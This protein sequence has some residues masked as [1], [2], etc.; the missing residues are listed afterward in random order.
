MCTLSDVRVS[1]KSKNL[2]QV[3]S[4][5]FNLPLTPTSESAHVIPAVLFDPENVDVA[6]AISLPSCVQA[7]LHADL[8]Q[9]YIT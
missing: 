4:A 8:F 6:F 7:Q 9:V 1:S 5:I 2:L 3:M